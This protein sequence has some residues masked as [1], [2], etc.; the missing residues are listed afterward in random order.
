[1]IWDKLVDRC[2]LFTD[3]P[4]GLLKALLKEAEIEL[5]NKLELYDALYTLKV[6]TTLKGLGVRSSIASTLADHNY[7]KLPQGYLRDISVTHEGV[8]LRKMT[9]SEVYRQSDGQTTSGTPTAYG[10]SGDYI[11]FDTTP[12]ADDEFII[13]YKSLLDESTQHKPVMI[14]NYNANVGGSNDYIFLDTIL[15]S[16]LD[17][18]KI[19][20]EESYYTIASGTNAGYYTAPGIPDRYESN[21][22]G[23]GASLGSGIPHFR[24]S[25][26]TLGADVTGGSVAGDDG[27]NSFAGSMCLVDQYRSVAPVIPEQ[28][29]IDL[30]NY[31]IAVSNAKISPETYNLYW[32]QWMLNMDNLVNEAQDR[33]LIFSVREEI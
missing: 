21:M 18:K 27:V 8:K 3:A 9:E 23:K 14:L 28:F 31:A 1:M 13:L 22:M 7:H 16:L 19:I 12:E 15:G 26:Y 29:H 2:L 24:G 20:I 11:V 10:I 33:D 6:P 4:G 25:R 17:N 30:C 32:S 5:A